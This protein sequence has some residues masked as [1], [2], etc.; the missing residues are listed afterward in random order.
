VHHGH[1]APF[2]HKQIMSVMVHLQGKLL[3]Q[4]AKPDKRVYLGDAK[5]V[6]TTKLEKRKKAACSLKSKFLVFMKGHNN[7]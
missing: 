5:F 6:L 7:M 1:I 3:S 2:Y 4:T